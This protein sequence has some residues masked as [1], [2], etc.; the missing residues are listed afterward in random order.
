MGEIFTSS[1]STHDL[2]TSR[3]RSAPNFQ[4]CR[5]K[6]KRDLPCM[7]APHNYALV[8]SSRPIIFSAKKRALFPPSAKFVLISATLVLQ[9]TPIKSKTHRL[10]LG[11]GTHFS[12]PTSCPLHSSPPPHPELPPRE[13]AVCLNLAQRTSEAVQKWVD[14]SCPA[15]PH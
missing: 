15:F 6:K 13:F 7:P 8:G 12:P 14:L 2:D 11:A 10:I 1:W 3:S 4:G 5:R 9:C